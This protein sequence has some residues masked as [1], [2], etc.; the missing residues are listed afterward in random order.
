MIEIEVVDAAGVP[1]GPGPIWTVLTWEQATRLDEAGA[2][3]FSMPAGDP[4]AALLLSRRHAKCYGYVGQTRTLLGEIII[5]SVSTHAGEDGA[6][7]LEVSGSD[8]LMELA[9]RTVKQLGL[10]QD[11]IHHPP[12]AGYGAFAPLGAVP[13]LLDDDETTFRRLELG[14]D[15]LFVGDAETFDFVRWLFHAPS[16]G[17]ETIEAQYWDGSEWAAL[18]FQ[19]DTQVDGATLRRSGDYRLDVPANWAQTTLEGHAAYWVKLH[20][21]SDWVIADVAD[22][23]VVKRHPDGDALS[24]IMQFAPTG[25]TLDTSN[26]H[27]TTGKPVLLFAEGESVLEML[28]MVAETTGEHFRLGAGRQIVWMRRDQSD[29]GVYAV[30]AESGAAS[31]GASELCLIGSV[32]RTLNAGPVR[33]RVYPMGADDLTLENT[34][35]TAPA[36]YTLNKGANYLEHDAAVSLYGVIEQ[37][38]VKREIKND[39]ADVPAQVEAAANALFDAALEWLNVHAEPVEAYSLSVVKVDRH[40]RVGQTIRVVYDEWRD[41]YHALAID[42]QLHILGVTYQVDATG[43]TLVVGLDVATTDRLP[44]SSRH[45]GGAALVLALAGQL[46][47]VPTSTS[48]GTQQAVGTTLGQGTQNIIART[49]EVRT[50]ANEPLLRVSRDDNVLVIGPSAHRGWTFD[51]DRHFCTPDMLSVR[52]GAGFFGKPAVTT[53]PVVTGAN[54]AQKLASLLLALDNLGLIDDQSA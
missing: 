25:W 18:S 12:Y 41:G 44:A 51:G 5:E 22:L 26:G 13:E 7:V 46:R 30:Q 21:N 47:H 14:S 23:K 53:R 17:G 35:R 40:L 37:W 52:S 6:T 9:D 43:S 4:L 31:E 15:W 38:L 2:G 45:S 1:L 32:Q 16:W 20:G 28:F 42:D 48:A 34:T 36:G 39:F 27:A 8:L 24:K 54:D 19:D 29:S 50:R 3:S 10:Y 33:T 11:D 49:L